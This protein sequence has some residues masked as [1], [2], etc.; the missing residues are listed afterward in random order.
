MTAMEGNA[1]VNQ[2]YPA[3]RITGEARADV[4]SA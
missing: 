1:P 2:V 4:L 3:R